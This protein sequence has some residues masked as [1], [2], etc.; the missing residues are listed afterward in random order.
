MRLYSSGQ[1]FA[2]NSSNR[3]EE[4]VEENRQKLKMLLIR[5]M[6]EAQKDRSSMIYL[7]I[8]QRSEDMER[9]AQK[10]MALTHDYV[11]AS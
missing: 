6:R 1:I 5:Q 7:Q 2:S 3:G 8:A 11:L 9:Q 10:T 4:F